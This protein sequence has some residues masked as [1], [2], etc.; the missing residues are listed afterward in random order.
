M[1]KEK[2]IN[3]I[4]VVTL[5]NLAYAT[6]DT[7]MAKRTTTTK[8]PDSTETSADTTKTPDAAG[9]KTSNNT[10]KSSVEKSH[11]ARDAK[12]T[13]LNNHSVTN[14]SKKLSAAKTAKKDKNTQQPSVT[15][16]TTVITSNF[17]SWTGGSGTLTSTQLVAAI[18][19]PAITN[20]QEAAVLGAIAER[21]NGLTTWN[22]SSLSTINQKLATAGYDN[23][24][25]N[26][27]YPNGATKS[28][29]GMTVILTPVANSKPQTYTTQVTF[30]Q[31]QLTYDM[32]T[33]NSALYNRYTSS[34]AN[35]NQSYT[36]DGKPEL[37]Y[38]ATH[39]LTKSTSLTQGAVGDC[40]FVSSVNAMLQSDPRS[41]ER[42]IKPVRGEPNTYSVKFPGDSSRIIVQLT[43]AEVATAS[44]V[45]GGGVWL[46]VLS[47]AEAQYR[48]N[49]SATLGSASATTIA[50]SEEGTLAML[51]GGTEVQT[52]K[53]MTGESYQQISI[54]NSSTSTL[55]NGFHQLL[56]KERQMANNPGYYAIKPPMGINTSG[57]ALLI[58]GYDPSTQALLILNP[59][60]TTGYYN[61][62]TMG[63]SETKPTSTTG[64]QSFAMQNG[65]FS[66]PVSELQQN[67]FVGI[68]VQ[69]S[70]A[71][72]FK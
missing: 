37:G 23:A 32:S 52:F 29:Q 27:S 61:P 43:P 66:I 59:W 7:A 54:T 56:G 3:A 38:T 25:T 65:E 68:A 8:S 4:I 60:G 10:T 44:Q 42:M 12:K 1:I 69:N 62:S 5:A 33:S 39:P 47:N 14:A 53:L 20:R 18:S 48:T 67:D 28:Y 46:A 55:A 2:F 17:K 63:Y 30:T 22:P 6:L 26:G 36:A 40:Y 15:A 11:L 71:K 45:K 70:I 35:L 9:D 72:D 49:S 41:L 16:A 34:L 50:T 57:H 24:F 31:Q 21:T 58:V 64:G 51:H 19:N 13:S